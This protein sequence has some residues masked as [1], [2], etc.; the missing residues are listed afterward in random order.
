M[1]QDEPEQ[2]PSRGVVIFREIYASSVIDIVWEFSDRSNCW[3]VLSFLALLSKTQNTRN[4][5]VT[6]AFK[7]S[8]HVRPSK[9]RIESLRMQVL[10]HLEA[11]V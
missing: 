4:G 6:A 11:F 7:Y 3:V 1:T 10:L 5:A 9:L 2:T 8:V